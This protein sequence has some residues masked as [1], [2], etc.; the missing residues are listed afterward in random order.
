MPAP[1][2]PRSSVP[3][4]DTQRQHQAIAQEISAALERVAAS[5]RFV[6]GPDCEILERRLAEY[7]A[8]RH[9]L[10]CAS[11]SDALLLALIA[12]GVGP[13]HEVLVPS[14]TFFATASAVWRLGACPV[15]VE[16][17]PHGFNLDPDDLAARITPATRAI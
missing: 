2:P 1:A 5:G 7:T 17:E 10:G 15:F 14:Y 12:C 9:A 8:A 13:G 16:I 11:G 6:L 4:F 3:L